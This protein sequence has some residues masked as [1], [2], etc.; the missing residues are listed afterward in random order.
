MTFIPEINQA[1]TTQASS[2][3]NAPK[4]TAATLGQEDFLTL[5]VAQLQ[6][7]DPLN[8][9]DPTEFTA[10]LAQFSELEQLFKLNDTMAL[11][12][13]SQNSNERLSALSLIGKDVLV[14]GS[15]FNYDG[16]PTTIGY[17]IDGPAA[18]AELTILNSLGQQVATIKPS[19]V[20]EGNHLITW[21]GLDQDGTALPPGDYSIAI[22]AKSTGDS[23]AVEV[24]PLVRSEV[25]GVDLTGN[26]AVLLTDSGE[27]TLSEIQGV[28]DRNTPVITDETIEDTTEDTGVA[29]TLS[30]LVSGVAED[31]IDDQPGAESGSGQE[32]NTF[33]QSSETGT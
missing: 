5:L 19:D 3:E 16:S 29:D 15:E 23:Q 33:V 1:A 4:A 25:T 27:Y 31:V 21:D 18:N 10:Q 9:S 2:Q 8:P 26:S 7:Q 32:A 6:N 28:Y 13:E 17:S 30:N 24:L 12:A 20:S 22:Q 14:S 11:L